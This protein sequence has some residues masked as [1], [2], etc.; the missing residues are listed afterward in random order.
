MQYKRR[1][2]RD[3]TRRMVIEKAM[4]KYGIENFSF[5]ILEKLEDR[6]ETLV[7][8]QYWIDCL[9]PFD[10]IGYNVNI[11]AS[12]RMG[13]KTPPEVKLKMSNTRKEKMASGEIKKWRNRAILQIDRDTLKILAEFPSSKEAARHFG[14]ER[15][16]GITLACS[17]IQ[18]SAR[19]FYWC[20]KDSYEKNG[21]CPR[22]YKTELKKNPTPKKV[23]EID[24]TGNIIKTWDSIRDISRHL[25]CSNATISLRCNGKQSGTYKG[26]TWQFA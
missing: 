19:G 17:G 4:I 13:M 3:A 25:G 26:S 18:V 15:S 9:K 24:S 16:A 1:I 2:T 5:E 14:T 23:N 21:F 10:P 8:E 6:K 22:E 11:Q 12:S 7:R 20:W